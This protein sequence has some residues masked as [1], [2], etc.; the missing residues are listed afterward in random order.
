MLFRSE[1]SFNTKQNILLSKYPNAQNVN[2]TKSADNKYDIAQFT[3]SKERSAANMLD[4]IDVWFGS[5][6]AIRL[7]KE[8]IS[9]SSLPM[10]VRDAF[11]RT[12]CRPL[13]EISNQN[14]INTFYSN[15]QIWEIDDI[16]L[17]EKDGIISYRIE[18]ETVS[19]IKPEVEMVLVYDAQ[20]ILIREYEAFD[21]DD[22]KPLEI[23]EN[24]LRWIDENFPGSDILN[25]ECDVDD[26]EIE[27]EIG[28]ANV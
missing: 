23:P 11:N 14:L 7:I 19:G 28:R 5:N 17:L 18:V 24:I 6:N 21:F 12:I 4:Q 22:V 8:E 20:G 27:H 9:F 26:D 1:D 2:W 25:Y 13:K 10:A 16:Y 3:L 15:Q